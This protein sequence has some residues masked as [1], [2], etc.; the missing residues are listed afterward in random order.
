M[1][2]KIVV[3]G[4][5]NIDL[6]MKMD[7]L[8][9][10]GETVGDAEFLQVYGGKGANQAVG[11][12][13]AGG[14][15][16][17]ISCVGEDAYTPQMLQNYKEDGIDTS[18]VFQEKGLSSGHALIMIG[19]AGNN[20]ISVAPGANYAL[21]REKIG[22]AM[23]IIDQASMII[24]QFEILADTIK[25]IIDIAHEKHIPVMWNF[26]PAREF[27]MDYI[28]RTNILAVNEVETELLTGVKIND[29]KSAEKAALK[30][31]KKGTEIVLLTLGSK[32]ALAF[33]KGEQHFVPA[34]AVN[35]V[36]TTAAGDVFCGC[37][38]VARTEGKSLKEGLKFANAAAALC[39]T[40]MGAQPSAP[41]RE[42]IEDFL[43]NN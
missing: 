4:S 11:A 37:F 39:V 40:K 2:N 14:N 36:D 16:A 33:S 35:A 18:Y 29:Q 31:L 12:A 25:Y 30:L 7:R 19:D 27:D 5:S 13:R 3:I 20:Y 8:P 9:S 1:N 28:A 38:A 42:Q 21:D 10:R 23:P 22:K 26:A 6:I 32:G 43:K 17:F 24:L 41:S 34:F 15:V